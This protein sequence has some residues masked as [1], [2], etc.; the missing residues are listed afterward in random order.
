MGVQLRSLILTL[1]VW[2]STSA[3]AQNPVQIVA[4]GHGP[5]AARNGPSSSGYPERLGSTLTAKGHDVSMTNAGVWGDTTRKV[6]GR[7]HRDVPEGTDIVLLA[8][9][10][11]DLRNG[12]SPEIVR[13]DIEAIVGCLR[14]KGAEV[15][16][17]GPSARTLVVKVLPD[18]TL[19]RLQRSP[20]NALVIPEATAEETARFVEWTLPVVEAAIFRVR[21][22]RAATFAP[23]PAL[24]PVELGESVTRR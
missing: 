11:Q 20:G 17:I 14:A 21:G 18:R 5:L 16:L 4:L 7:L 6:M 1:L 2:A 8:I 15:I 9:G 22:R 23:D 12:V 13:I 24:A 3:E 19:V 10:L